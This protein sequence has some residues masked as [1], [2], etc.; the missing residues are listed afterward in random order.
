MRPDAQADKTL[1]RLAAPGL[2]AL[3]R[4]GRRV[5]LEKESLRIEPDAAI[6]RTPHPRGLGSALTHPHISTDFSEAL[7]ELITPP[8]ADN[9]AA[10][11]FLDELHGFVCRRIGDEALWVN[12][13]PC[14]V[15]DETAI[16]LARY[17]TSN[18]GRMK[19]IYR[20]GLGWRYGRAM[21]LVA[22]VHYN[23]SFSPALWPH[24][25][26]LEGSREAPQAFRSRRYMGLIRN[27]LRLGWV[28]P[29]LFGASPAVCKTYIDP[30]TPLEVWDETTRY[31]PHA[32][33][34][35][36]GDIGYQNN[37][38]IEVGM[39]ASYD[40][41]DAYVRS[42]LWAVNTPFK[43]YRKIG[44]KV[45]G[46][47]RQ[48]SANILQIENEYYA[49][50][51]PKRSA[52]KREMPLLALHRGGVEYIE[53]RSLDL[54]PFAPAGVTAEQLDFIEALLLLCLVSD[55]PPLGADE[56]RA[57]DIN[58]IR[59]AHDGRAPGATLLDD[60]R[61]TPLKTLGLALCDALAP[62]CEALD[63]A[64]A[65]ARYARALAQQRR[66]FEDPDA[67][68]S[69]RLLAAL[70][71]SGHS[72]AEYTLLRSLAARAAQLAAPA[73]D[74]T[75]LEE[76]AA[77]SLREQRALEDGDDM[78]L[79]DYIKAYFSLLDSVRCEDG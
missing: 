38:N 27:L 41:L 65:T 75:R 16:P 69:A 20:R 39:R 52:D 6:A 64:M 10:I 59:A 36:M 71:N 28:A 45:A 17:G 32:T 23:Y 78:P 15:K 37:R 66:R 47:F 49:S 4:D 67:T 48:L 40:S 30:A 11:A 5:G 29:Y 19:T 8:L 54:D 76:L 21:Q 51:R 56:R 50:V 63:A 53:L 25:Q 77:H 1:A 7:L 55:S 35:R 68:P 18:L 79:D 62:A 70:R 9:R 58:E 72:F 3:L 24:L 22:G 61:T 42:L 46:K 60:G 12:S 73:G 34:L 57:I 31:G 74:E 26:E 43:P 33:S 13:M 2:G 14:I 44:V